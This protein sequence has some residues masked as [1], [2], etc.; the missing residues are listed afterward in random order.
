MPEPSEDIANT[1]LLAPATASAESFSQGQVVVGKY[2][3]VSLLG[4]GGIGSVYKVEQVFLGQYFA[5]KT[6]NSQTASDQLIRRFQNEARAASSLSHPNLVKV[7]DFGLLE[8][9]QPYL[10][11]DLV[12]GITLSEHIKE[13]G[14][15][16]LEQVVGCFAQVCLGLSYAHE[17]GI[18]HRDI[19]PSNIMISRSLPFGAEGF[20]KVVDFGIAKLVSTEDGEIQSL[21]STGE[22]FGSPLYMSPEQCSGAAVDHRADIYSLGCV[23]FET[24]TGTSPFVGQN[25]LSTM[26]LHQSETAPTLK[27]ASLGKEFPPAL[28]QVVAKLLAKKPADRYQNLG[29]VANDL[30]QIVKGAPAL[31][32]SSTIKKDVKAAAAVNMT[33]GEFQKWIA[34]TAIGVGLASGSIAYFFANWQN[35]VAEEKRAAAAAAAVASEAKSANSRPVSKEGP[36]LPEA[37]DWTKEWGF[38]ATFLDKKERYKDFKNRYYATSAMANEAGPGNLMQ[39]RQAMEQLTQLLVVCRQDKVL[40]DEFRSG[41]EE[42]IGFCHAKLNQYSQ[43]DQFLQMALLS[44][45]QPDAKFNIGRTYEFMS[46]AVRRN[47]KK[48]LEY[49]LA[50]VTAMLDTY[51]TKGLAEDIHVNA[52]RAVANDYRTCGA[53]CYEDYKDYKK[54]ED[55][56]LSAR[57]ILQE[58]Y[59]DYLNGTLHMLLGAA[60]VGQNR[61]EEA[62]AALRTSVSSMGRVKRSIAT[63]DAPLYTCNSYRQLCGVA[64]MQGDLE[65]ARKNLLNAR[66]ALTRY[67]PLNPGIEPHRERMIKEIDGELKKLNNKP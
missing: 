50:A 52:G 19:K 43:A 33:R 22:I 30:A 61:L 13:K 31:G 60:L 16:T 66:G 26:M 59:E 49:R 9:Q 38:G 53:I 11:M 45:K 1:R 20:V 37:G 7:I 51:N 12:D 21:T 27:E 64:I 17:Q 42:R 57:K 5:L 63:D 55:Y 46:E 23:L 67:R 62:K 41:L 6:L 4:R 58:V 24:L 56:C 35:A 25:A 54:A 32:V 40:R 44:A 28:E 15:F 3:I 8:G 36:M 29:I 39:V 18:V 48:S 2:K 10:V 14:V 65:A 47:T 34:F